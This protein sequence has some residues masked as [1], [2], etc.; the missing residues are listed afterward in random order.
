MPAESLSTK[1]LTKVE[2]SAV[3]TG[4]EIG[5]AVVGGETGTAAGEGTVITGDAEAFGAT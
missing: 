3:I 2:L 1:A 5:R 4:D